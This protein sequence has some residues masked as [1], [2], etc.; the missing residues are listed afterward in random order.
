MSYADFQEFLKKKG[1]KSTQ[2]LSSAVNEYA[3][4]LRTSKVS[5][6][7]TNPSQVK[8]QNGQE[9]VLVQALPTPRTVQPT[10]SLEEIAGKYN[11]NDPVQVEQYF[12]EAIQAQRQNEEIAKQNQANRAQTAQAPV[13]VQQRKFTGKS[14][15]STLGY[16]G[17]KFVQGVKDA[18]R[19]ILNTLAT[20][21]IT[22]Y[23]QETQ[24][25]MK[26]QLEESKFYKDEGQKLLDMVTE[27]QNDVKAKKTAKAEQ[28]LA[29]NAAKSAMERQYLEDKY[30]NVS[31]FGKFMGSA[32]EGAGQ[33]LPAIGI[34]MAT[35]GAGGLASAASSASFFATAKGNSMA[36]AISQGADLETAEAYGNMSALSETIIEWASGGIGGLNARQG[37]SGLISRAANSKVGKAVTK[38]ADNAFINTTKKFLTSEPGKWL[39]SRIAGMTGEGVEEMVSEYVGPLLQRATYDPEAGMPTMEDVQQAFLGGFGA[40]GIMGVSSDA[41]NGRMLKD[42]ARYEP[43]KI[44]SFDVWDDVEAEGSQQHGNAD[45]NANRTSAMQNQAWSVD[46]LGRV[47]T[48][49]ESPLLLALPAPSTR[50]EEGAAGTNNQGNIVRQQTYVQ[51]DPEFSEL[52]F[53]NTNLLDDRE[54]ALAQTIAHAQ[55]DGKTDIQT[56]IESLR[57]DVTRQDLEDSIFDAISNRESDLSGGKGTFLQETHDGVYSGF[58]RSSRNPE[59]YSAYREKHGKVPTTK[60]ELRQAA[61][62][63]VSGELPGIDFFAD[64]D[65]LNSIKTNESLDKISSVLQDKNGDSFIGFANDGDSVV[66]QYGIANGYENARGRVDRVRGPEILTPAEAEQ[67]GLNIDELRKKEIPSQSPNLRKQNERTSITPQE[68]RRMNQESQE[69][70][71]R[72]AQSAKRLGVSI[73]ASDTVTRVA[74][75]LRKEVEFAELPDGSEGIYQGS[76]GK[77]LISPTAQ[78]PALQVLKHEFTHDLERS[79]RYHEFRQFVFSYI[80]GGGDVEEY[81]RIAREAYAQKGIELS[82]KEL[83]HEIVA[84]AAARL[85]SDEA[86][87]ELA[88]QREAGIVQRAA[89]WVRMQIRKFRARGDAVAQDL[90]RAQQIYARVMR[91]RRLP[92]N[93]KAFFIAYDQNGDK[94]SVVDGNIFEGKDKSLSRNKI[95]KDYISEHIG[96]AYRIAQD[97]EIVY[98]GK[99]LPGE[100]VYSKSANSLKKGRKYAKY[101]VAQNLHELIEIAEEKRFSENK[102]E[103]HARDA[104]FGWYRYDSKFAVPKADGKDGN[105]YRV[106]DCS[107]VI[108]HDGDGKKYLY[109]VLIKNESRE[110]A[111][112]STPMGST[113]NADA[114]AFSNNITSKSS[115]VNKRQ[116]ERHQIK[117]PSTDRHSIGVNLMELA[118]KYGAFKPGMEPRVDR[119]PVP[120]QTTPDT[121]VSRTARTIY[122]SPNISDEAAEKIGEG[123]VQGK[124][125]YTPVTDKKARATAEATIANRGIDGA[126]KQWNAVVEGTT[127]ASKEKFVLG[128]ALMLDAFDRGDSKT[129][130][131]IAAELSLIARESGQTSQAVSLIKLLTP[132]G[133]LYRAQ[134]VVDNI[135]ESNKKIR[136]GKAPGIQISED[137]IQEML[138][139]KTQE[140]MNAVEGKIMEEVGKQTPVT[141]KDKLD[142]WRYLSMLGNPRTHLRNVAGN[143]TMAF[144]R[145]IKN[146]IAWGLERFV[147]KEN[148]TKSLHKTRDA[149]VFARQDWEENRK[150]ISSGGKYGLNDIVRDN[151]NIFGSQKRGLRT[152]SRGLEALRKFNDAALEVEDGWFLRGAYVDSLAQWMTA[153]GITAEQMRKNA[154]LNQEGRAYATQEALKATFRDASALADALNKMEKSGKFVGVAISGMMPFKK[155]PINIL[156]RG[157]EYSPLGLVKGLGKA[158]T[159]LKNGEFNASQFVD[160][161]AAGLTGTGVLMIGYWLSSLGIISAGGDDNDKKQTFDE[162]QGAQEYAIQLGDHTYTLDWLSP[163]TMPLFVGVELEKVLSDETDATSATARFFDSM[164]TV[165]DPLLQLSCLQGLNDTIS[166]FAS[167]D[168]PWEGIGNLAVSGATGYLGQFVPTIS[169]QTARTIDPVRRTTYASGEDG[170]LVK[171]GK[172]FLNKMMAKIPGLSSTLEP[173]VDLWGEEDEGTENVI[174]R[175]LENFVF[176]WYSNEKKTDSTNTELERLFVSTGESSVLPSY[177]RGNLSY[178]NKMVYLSPKVYTQYKKEY[179]QTA[180]KNLDSMIKSKEYKSLT[181]EEKAKAVSKVYQYT[182][183][184]TKKEAL[185]N[186]NIPY[187]DEAAWQWKAWNAEKRGIDSVGNYILITSKLDSFEADKDK[188]GKPITGSKKK[189][190]V[191]YL[192]SLGLSRKQFNFYMG[193]DGYAPYEDAVKRYELPMK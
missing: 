160:S 11:M 148:R 144:T 156:K 141:I 38:A 24:S 146:K 97:G 22:N 71:I 53:A 149:K 44:K 145:K 79:K 138:N 84:D 78:N 19:G 153:R 94:V 64:Q 120:K 172:Q 133:R 56:F 99:D 139:A 43:G 61:K 36:E 83:E 66:A 91:G 15:D 159:Q 150:I 169:G 52:E 176:P 85:L 93:R 107:L 173:Y 92:N 181:D 165:S 23:G 132:A 185:L 170:F 59:W 2:D 4:I 183:Y 130:M 48:N 162:M 167:G 46:P 125:S 142:A 166:G 27:F 65:V 192:N 74:N 77:I 96:E 95:V 33:M 42:P 12:Q 112:V 116:N 189:K 62:E 17:E 73:E 134:R 184:V 35:G 76:D 161:I 26:K 109:D 3:S 21:G 32:M 128:E 187:K 31:G 60:A 151:Q 90:I 40:A 164:T 54:L 45:T 20:T 131:K 147:K 126:M 129:G 88:Y 41:L 10:L 29:E 57:G 28:Y 1:V 9:N 50:I 111:V 171:T 190:V 137:L 87:I 178:D 174:V 51:N 30:A 108:R 157:V 104:K 58:K 143:I 113:M 191:T 5:N 67:R 163:V 122:E 82:S 188:N 7:N 72:I 175:A 154:T 168:T 110:S 106:Y 49:G 179:G 180:K 121:K 14:S 100:Y 101:Q 16:M 86:F 140:Q 89:D 124:F 115:P 6:R 68:F 105:R 127:R 103:R 75:A 182:G 114:S 119:G 39:T 155:T 123:I 80:R 186:S 8:L 18:G 55:R 63:I 70:A 158:L 135:N 81:K 37:L 136:S 98:I 118:E 117:E 102:K 34:S 193:I 47:Q 177:Q 69:R 13:N 152:I 25:T